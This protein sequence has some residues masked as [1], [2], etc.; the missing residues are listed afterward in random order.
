MRTRN[1]RMRSLSCILM[2]GVCFIC[3]GATC[4]RRN[5]ALTL[6]PPPPVLGEAPGL[7]EVVAAVNR[8]ASIRE[9]SSNSATVDVVSMPALPKLSATIALRRERDFRLRASLP[10]VMGS[11]LDMGS[12]NEMFWFEV[13]E[14]MARTLYYAR[15]DLYRQQLERA[16]LPVD[17]TWVTDSLG[18]VQIDPA[19][20]V[21]GPV[22]RPD[23]KLEIR[24]TLPMPAGVFQRVCYVDAAAGHVTDQ[25]LFSPSGV[26][27]AESHASNHQYYVEQ[28]CA[29]PH[30]VEF[31]LTPN[32]GPPL[33]MRI[34][35]GIYA[36][37]QILSGDPNLF[38]IPQGASNSVD[39]TTISATSPGVVIP[40]SYQSQPSYQSP[41][42]GP[43]PYRGLVR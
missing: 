30:T 39:L 40:T 35:V 15:H 25:F 21:A 43:M 7:P 38:V 26:R 2:L 23:G 42:I 18:L 11:G 33:E 20:V 34:D 12:N 16:V 31:S 4:S 28:Q 19:Q 3:G 24:S 6:P 32:S 13:P 22:R 9:L 5:V 36:V 37:N 1:A 8:T 10:I 29:L 14:G 17:P 41:D 27:I